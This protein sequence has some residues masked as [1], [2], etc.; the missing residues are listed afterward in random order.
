[1]LVLARDDVHNLLPPGECVEVMREALR[2]L[3]AGHV[4]QPLRMVVRPPEAAGLMALMPSFL[5]G[6]EPRFGLKAVC[7]F[8]GNPALGKDAHQGSVLLFDGGT[9]EPMA[10]ANGSAVTELRTAAVSAVATD[11]LARPD[12]SRTYAHAQRLADALGPPAVACE[13]T[14][15]AITGADIVVTVTTSAEP[16]LRYEWLAPGTHV[17]AVGSSIPT[18]R[19]IDTATMAAASLFV[20]RRESTVN[21]SGDYLFAAREG[22]IG[23]EHIRAE[24]G[25]VLAGT[26]PGRADPDEIT[27]FK[28]LGLAVEDLASV[29]YLYAKAQK[30]GVGT[31]VDF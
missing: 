3:A 7:V 11:A 21:E 26:A 8:H 1:M 19:E 22:A 17:N 16:V 12:A 9:G 10:L 24:I 25:D 29:S 27:L 5:G 4:H 30:L 15:D 14:M 20:D 31:W 18:S 2:S 13:S 6:D 23:P 28:S